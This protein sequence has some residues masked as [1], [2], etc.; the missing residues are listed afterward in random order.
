MRASVA[1]LLT[2]ATVF[3]QFPTPPEDT[4]TKDF[5]SYSISY[6]QTTICETQAKAWSGYIHMPSSYLGDLV[7]TNE[8][9]SLFFW[10]FE[11]RHNPEHAP[12]AIY[13]AGGPGQTS[14]YGVAWDGGPCYVLPDSNSTEENQWSWNEHANMLYLD[15]PVGT[16]YSYNELIDSNYDLLTNAITPFSAYTEDIPGPNATLLYGKFPSQDP[17]RTVN[18][19]E[20]AAR[21]LWY[22]AQAWFTDFPE[23]NTCD[24][25]IS[26]WGNSYGGYWVSSAAAYIHKQNA[27]IEEGKLDGKK[28]HLNQIGILNGCIDM[29]YQIEWYPQMAYNNTYDLAVINETIYQAAL[30]NYHKSGGC[31]DKIR[32]CRKLGEQFDP[33]QLGV[34]DAVNA[35]CLKAQN[36]CYNNVIGAFEAYSQV[37]DVNSPPYHQRIKPLLTPPASVQPSTW[38]RNCQTPSLFHTSQHSSTKTGYNVISAFRST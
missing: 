16:G 33:E 20:A 37:E 21:T 27:K 14:M 10:Y 24:K 35:T 8:T 31:A 1:A 13:L 32:Q 12:T 25:R 34:N 28:L 5:D 6:K 4:I 11:A 19:T 22:F 15:Q 3:A 29:E 26:L 17:S 30:Q 23:Y 18:T 36:Y 38:R 9:I 7:P 2:A